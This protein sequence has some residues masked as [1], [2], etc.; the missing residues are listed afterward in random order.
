MKTRLTL[1]LLASLTAQAERT[2]TFPA[3]VEQ[4]IRT[5]AGSAP[6]ADQTALLETIRLRTMPGVRAETTWSSSENLNLL[7]EADDRLDAFTA[8]VWVDYPLLDSGAGRRRADALRTEVQLLRRRASDEAEAV[9]HETLEAFAQLYTAEQRIRLLHTG[10]ARAAELRRRAQTMLDSGDISHLT[11]AQWQDQAL[12]TESQLVDLELQRLEAETRLK[13]LV[14]DTST[15][16][17]HASLV[18]DDEPFLREIKAEQVV[19]TD[20]AVARASILQ[21]RQSLELQ[22]ATSLRRPQ[23]LVSAFGGVTALPDAYDTAIQDDTFG[24]FGLRLS[25][26]LPMFDSASALRV[27]EA[28]LQLE[29]ASRARR[30]AE[31]AT[32]NRIDL[33]WLAV[34]AADKRIQLL[35]DAVSVAKQRQ[36]SVTRLVLA[37]V[38]PEADLVETAN[39]VARRESDLLAVRVDRWKLQQRVRFIGTGATGFPMQTASR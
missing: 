7:S 14:G 32:R 28:R 33:M 22:E 36:E 8:V 30:A 3:A 1:L 37:G 9:F 25:L 39:A 6:Y 17:L 11:A 26:S 35:T 21:Q 12:A 16:S 5:R 20:A 13:Q 24:I 38:R 2:V 4:A 19:E 29:E 18:L 23:L 34:A 27:A 15:E 10:A 31:A